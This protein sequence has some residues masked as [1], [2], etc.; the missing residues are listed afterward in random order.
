[1]LYLSRFATIAY[2]DGVDATVAASQAEAI[3]AIRRFYAAWNV[4][5]REQALPVISPQFVDHAGPTA[6]AYGREGFL[7]ACAT[8][9]ELLVDVVVQV[10]D[11]LPAERG[12]VVALLTCSAT[13]IGP[14]PGLPFTGQPRRV[15]WTAIN[16]FRLEHG[17]LVERWDCTGIVP[18]QRR[19]EVCIAG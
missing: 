3:A 19:G 16:V 17:Q 15:T 10:E 8:I 6:G 14:F 1:M 7:L 18:A 13:Q 11:L 9:S 2:D 5:Q 4:H 12:C